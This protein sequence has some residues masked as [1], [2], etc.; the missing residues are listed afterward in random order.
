MSCVHCGQQVEPAFRYCPWC[1]SA[2]RRKLVEFFRGHDDFDF[3]RSLRVSRYFRTRETEPH[4]RFS[5]WNEE[6]VAQAAVSIDEDEAARLGALLAPRPARKP[7]RS[8]LG[9]HSS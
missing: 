7:R 3:G 5:V 2:Q 4:V 9:L 1:G 8:F 6:G